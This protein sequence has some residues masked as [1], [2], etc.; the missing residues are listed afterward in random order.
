MLEKI[1]HVVIQ[2]YHVAL[3][4]FQALVPRISDL[5]D[6]VILI[7]T[8]NPRTTRITKLVLGLR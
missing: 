2:L 7:C 1:S 4:I 8:K 3:I 5:I 6:S